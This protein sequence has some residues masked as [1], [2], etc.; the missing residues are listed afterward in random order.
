M[1]QGFWVHP[2]VVELLTPGSR[3]M[4]LIHSEFSSVTDNSGPEVII[5]A[6]ALGQEPSWD[7][8]S[9]PRP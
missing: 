8:K 7:H 4:D 9:Q 5:K 6:G 2:N 3:K 1:A